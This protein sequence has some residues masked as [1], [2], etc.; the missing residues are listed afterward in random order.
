MPIKNDSHVE[1]HLHTLI[2][3]YIAPNGGQNGDLNSIRKDF[4]Q[5]GNHLPVHYPNYLSYVN[6]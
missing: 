5:S 4:I 3:L 1:N 2:Y 6:T